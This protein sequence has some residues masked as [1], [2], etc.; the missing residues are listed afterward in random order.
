MWAA[1]AGHADIV[2]LLLDAG[3]DVHAATKDGWT[4]LHSAAAGGYE[5]VIGTLVRRGARVAGATR[6]CV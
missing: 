1:E 2:A 3:A 5:A 4:A 6:V